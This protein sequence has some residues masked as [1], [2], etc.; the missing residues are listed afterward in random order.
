LRQVR[1]DAGLKQGAFAQRLGIPLSR[2]VSYEIARAPIRCRLAY[3]A[4]NNFDVNL[5]WLAT[6]M[7]PHRPQFVLE[8]MLQ[9]ALPERE[10]FSKIYEK[11]LSGPFEEKFSELKKLGWTE[12]VL[13]EP[14]GALLKKLIDP[15][16]PSSLTLRRASLGAISRRL[17]ELAEH[18]P[19]KVDALIEKFH[20]AI[21]DFHHEHWNELTEKRGVPA[22][23]RPAAQEQRKYRDFVNSRLSRSPG[24]SPTSF[25]EN[26]RL[27]AIH[28]CRRTPA[29]ENRIRPTPQKKTIAQRIS[30]ALH[31]TGLTQTEA[32]EKWKINRRTLEDWKQGRRE[33]H[34]LYRDKIEQV[35]SKIE[36]A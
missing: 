33:P 13:N 35:L 16:M 19:E 29:D 10:L 30:D 6:G 12:G 31:K 21:S 20:D 34:G 5:R 28:A 25:Y 9:S 14:I 4:A 32:S 3:D 24:E 26:I 22:E 1:L 36:A 23:L 15:I 27:T 7:E 18:L 2:L 11:I 8:P 17:E